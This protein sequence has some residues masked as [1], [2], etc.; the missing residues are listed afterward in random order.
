MTDIPEIAERL[1]AGGEASDAELASLLTAEG[2]DRDALFEEARRVRD[3]EFGKRTYLYGFVYFSTYCRNEC[4]FCYYRKSNDI[5]RYRKS[6]DELVELARH[7]KADGLDLA[8]LTMGEDPYMIRNGYENFLDIVSSIKEETGLNIM[9]SPGAVPEK[10]FP[11]LR[12]AGADICACYQETYNRRLFAERRLGQDFE[13]RRNQKIWPMRYGMLAEDGMM[14]GIGETVQDRVDTIREMV[15]LGCDQIRAMAFVPQ[16]G[17]PMQDV[18]VASSIDELRCIAVMRLLQHDAFIPATLDVEGIAG[19]RTRLDAGA[20]TVTSIIPAASHLA[21]VA[22]SEMDIE[23]GHRCADYVIARLRE[24]GREPAT[25]SDLKR[26]FDRR[27]KRLADRTDLRSPESE[28]FIR[29]SPMGS[30]CRIR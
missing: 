22:Q 15:S 9:A 2:P 14:V 13:Y 25:V 12:D 27:K 3:R 10:E 23:D 20:S 11:K 19:M 26:E 16:A 21:G 24:M 4:S 30:L 1:A 8:D 6:K 29:V 5:D 17:T 28:M 18:P 7:I